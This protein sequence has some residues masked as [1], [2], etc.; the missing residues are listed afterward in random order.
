MYERLAGV[1]QA[2]PD[3]IQQR[4]AIIED[5]A[6]QLEQNGDYKGARELR[7]QRNNLSVSGN[8][9]RVNAELQQQIMAGEIVNQAPIARAFSMGQISP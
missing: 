9:Q 1:N 8:N 3:A 6:L 7:S 5:S 2:A 4:D